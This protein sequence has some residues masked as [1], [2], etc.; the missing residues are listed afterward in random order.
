[1]EAMD[2]LAQHVRGRVGDFAKL[3]KEGKK[4]IGYS[5]GDFM[6]EDMII[7]V[8][9]VPV[10]LMRGGTHEPVAESSAYLPRFIDTFCRAQIGYKMSGDDPLYQMVDNVVITLSENN[11]R[12]IADCWDFYTDV[13]TYRFGVPHQ[14]DDVALEY[15][16]EGIG[17]LGEGLEELV[18]NKLD[19]GKLGEE[20]ALTN[21]MLELLEKISELRQSANPPI[22]GK[23][24]IEL[25][26][27][28]YYGDKAFV[29]ECLEEIYN[30]LRDKQ[31][32]KPEARI[33]VVGST[34]AYGDY[35]I[36]DLVE[37]AGAVIVVEEFAEGMRHYW[38]RVNLNGDLRAALAD[39]NFARRVPPAWF[40]PAAKLRIEFA[41]KL[42]KDYAVDGIIWYNLMYRDS[43]D[44]Q[45]YYFEKALDKDMG[46]KTL[47]VVSD[48]DTSEVGPMKTRIEAFVETLRR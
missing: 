23:Q 29:L 47:K 17:L 28:S 12:A 18:G 20:I 13:K 4:L 15:F 2:K 30:G 33:M 9:A 10:P 41:E 14:R 1:M 3:K 22:T 32:P 40:R 34:L 27:A 26:H 31:G 25:Q 6:P 42:A 11:T 36:Y 19:E 5:P 16:T 35:K 8:G 24:F 38:Q 7:A 37:E 46:L 39:R 45:Y 44:I 48:Y 21:K 43:Y